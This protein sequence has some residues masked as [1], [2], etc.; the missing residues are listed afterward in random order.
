M[1]LL[2]KVGLIYDPLY[3]W[4]DTGAHP[5]SALRLTAIMHVLT[6]AGL[7][8]RLIPLPARDATFDE[9]ALVHEPAYIRSIR[10]MAAKGGAWAD[11]DT[12]ISPRS[13]DAA[14][15][16]AGGCLA[17]T[18]AVLDGEIEGAFCLVRPPGHHA[19]YRQAMG[20]CIFDNVA[21][22]ARYANRRR[23][24]ERIAIVDFDIHH[25]NGTQDAFYEDGAVLYFS[26]HQYPYYPGT[27]H[28][29]E[30]GEG[31]GRGLNVN[32]PLPAG[33]GD[34]QFRRVFQEVL[35]PV[36]ERFQPQFLFVSAG[37]DGHFADPLA[38]MALSTPG[39]AELMTFLKQ[40]AQQL[41][42]GKLVVV[43]EGGYHL[44]AQ[45][46]S[47][48]VS[49]EVLLGEPP[50]KDPFGK[51]QDAADCDIDDVL[52]AVKLLHGLSAAEANM[53]I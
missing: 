19:T 22:A 7:T 28:M 37:Y 41:C 12:F 53:R 39:Y 6:E 38:S 14:I 17:A 42:D 5:E 24:L 32:V 11:P 20:F 46:W 21:I 40:E 45:A 23:G 4:H 50:G 43:L 15:R 18:E 10:D 16:A 8:S 48:R 25:G 27:G 26:T 2:K 31:P 51:P 13:Y 52:K 34:D 30:I 33:C 36:L 47:V 29:E 3:L 35:G 44:M 49:I 1:L 9:V